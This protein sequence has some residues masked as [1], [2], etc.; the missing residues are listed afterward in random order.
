MPK[1]TIELTDERYA[2]LTATAELHLPEGTPEDYLQKV[3]DSA[4][5]SYAQ[6]YDQTSKEVY[7]ARAEVAAAEKQAADEKIARLEA[8]VE[9]AK[10]ANSEQAAAESAADKLSRL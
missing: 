1:I 2:A 7:R 10:L 3:I 5:D 8:E 4:C 9:A 6:N